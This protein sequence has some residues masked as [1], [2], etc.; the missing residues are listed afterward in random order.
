MGRRGWVVDAV[1]ASVRVEAIVCVEW[2]AGAIRVDGDEE[3]KNVG[4]KQHEERK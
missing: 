4:H 2:G 3:R 1:V